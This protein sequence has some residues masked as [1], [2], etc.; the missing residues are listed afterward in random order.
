MTVAGVV[1]V[2]EKQ[3]CA[4]IHRRPADALDADGFAPV[5]QFG[6]V[7]DHVPAVDEA[8]RVGR[9]VARAAVLRSDTLAGVGN[10][11]EAA[12]HVLRPAAVSRTD[13]TSAQVIDAVAQHAWI[14]L[15]LVDVL[16]C[17]H[18]QAPPGGDGR[19]LAFIRCQLR[20]IHRQAVGIQHLRRHEKA[21]PVFRRHHEHT[22]GG[23]PLLFVHVNE[24]AATRQLLR[25]LGAGD[26]EGEFILRRVF[27]LHHGV[28]GL[29]VINRFGV[30][31]A[32]HFIAKPAEDIALIEERGA[33]DEV[34]ALGV[35]LLRHLEIHRLV[36]R[37][38]LVR[39]AHDAGDML[40]VDDTVLRVGMLQVH[41]EV[42]QVL[43]AVPTELLDIDL[44][45]WLVVAARG[46]GDVD[47]L[48]D[49]D[50][51][52]GGHVDAAVLA[53]LH[54]FRT[55]L[56]V[57][58]RAVRHQVAELLSVGNGLEGQAQ[59]VLVDG[60]GDALAGPRRGAGDLP[61]RGQQ[62]MLV[63][64]A[65]V[66]HGER[67]PAFRVLLKLVHHRPGDRCGGGNNE[68]SA[69]FADDVGAG[70]TIGCFR[71]RRGGD[72]TE[73]GEQVFAGGGESG[74]QQAGQQQ[75]ERKAQEHGGN[76]PE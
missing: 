61:R 25:L 9:R 2:I 22:A 67:R 7:A 4:G 27:R 56:H 26:G 57:T 54:G 64:V 14:G 35:L 6:E 53:G 5:R 39:Q 49:V 59:L 55:I 46:A 43:L 70:F 1:G 11:K 32:R 60:A 52:D 63:A 13:D 12:H 16:Q 21:R 51:A 40:V 72:I 31:Q 8:L 75:Q 66:E 71:G 34:V 19:L 23:D 44:I 3:R 24:R 18:G 17:F 50:A 65:Q 36:I 28:E 45:V 20:H 73:V 48:S 29:R 74:R 10:G 68:Q 42:R 58:G 62:Q 37:H 33:D 15:A 69:A 47:E 38:R 76:L 41:D 30:I